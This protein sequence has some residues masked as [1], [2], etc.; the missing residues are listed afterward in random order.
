MGDI[1]EK[2]GFST[3]A[4][5]GMIDKLETLDF[6][7]RIHAIED[8]RKILVKLTIRGAKFVKEMETII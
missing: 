6:V 8:R 5:T 4:A 1:A 2:F 7:E 3:A